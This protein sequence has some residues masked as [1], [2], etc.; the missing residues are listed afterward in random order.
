MK[1][2]FIFNNTK[3]NNLAYLVFN[4]SFS[5]LFITLLDL[6]KRVV[7]CK[8]S[9]ECCGSNLKKTKKSS[10]SIENIIERLVY[11]FELHQIQNFHIILKVKFTSHIVVLVKELMDRGYNIRQFSSQL[12]IAHNGLRGRKLRRI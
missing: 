7:I 3:N 8:T 10:Q 6:N 12:V 5:N 11:Y 9:G 1:D 2:K 4:K